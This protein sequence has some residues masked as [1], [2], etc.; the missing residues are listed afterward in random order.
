MSVPQH[1]GPYT[2]LHEVGRGAMGVV[3]LARDTR[4]DRNVALKMLPEGVASNPTRVA[5]FEREG[6][7]L[8]ALNHP[9]IAAIHGLEESGGSKY[10]VLEYVDG[11]TLGQRLRHGAMPLDEALKVCRQIAA[12]AEAAHQHGVIHRDLKPE[13]IKITP[14]GQVKILDFGLAKSVGADRAGAGAAETAT[15]HTNIATIPGATL[16]TPGYMSPEQTRGKPVDKRT[17]VWAFGCIL[18]ECL[19]GRMA[20]HGETVNDAIAAT[21]TGVPDWDHLPP[22]TPDR[23]RDL[24]LRCLEKDPNERQKDLGDARLDI[25]EATGDRSSSHIRHPRRRT[26]NNLPVQVTSFVGRKKELAEVRELLVHSRLVTITG[27]GGCG[28]TRLVLQFAEELVTCGD[29]PDGVWFA[30][31]AAL[32]D[33]TLVPE[34]VATPLGVKEQPGELLRDSLIRHLETKTTLLIIDNCEHLLSACAELVDALLH[35]CPNLRIITSSREGLAIAGEATYRVPSLPVPPVPSMDSPLSGVDVL[36]YEAVKLLAERAAA[37]MPSFS[38]ADDNAHAVARICQRLD[39]IPLAIELAAAR[40]GALSVDEIAKRLD[41]SFRLLTGG[42]RTALPRQRTLRATIDWSYSLLSEEEQILLRRF[43]VFSGGWHLEAAEK[44]CSDEPELE[45]TSASTL[46]QRQILD[47]MTSLVDKSLVVFEETVDGGGRYRL[48]ETVRQYAQEEHSSA[49]EGQAVRDRHVD[50][51]LALAE[52]A[53]PELRGADQAAWLQRLET[54]HENLL[55]ALE[56]CD[57]ADGGAVKALRLSG[58]LW[59]LWYIHGHLHL[60]LRALSDALGRDGATEPTAVRAKTL[61]AA[62][63]L[64]E[65]QSDYTAAKTLLEESLAIRRDLKDQRGIAQSLN[66]LGTVLDEQRDHGAASALYQ[67]A[68]KINRELGNRTAEAN[69]LNN[70]GHIALQLCD[71]VAARRL[72]EESLAIHCELGDQHG[73]AIALNNLG[74]VAHHQGDGSTAQARYQESLATRYDLG[75]KYGIAES[76]QSIAGYA[77]ATGAWE[78]TARLLGA[79]ERLREE[80][81]TALPPSDRA[82]HD[83]D[84]VAARG[85]L[86]ATAFEDIRAGGRAAP[87]EDTVQETLRWL[88]DRCYVLGKDHL[89]TGKS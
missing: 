8:A 74:Q 39:G 42:S 53:E 31:L 26:P 7:A 4:L 25:D 81:G 87:L 73:T 71:H 1:I 32:A 82:E 34:S 27:S 33:P 49:G 60:G 84:V 66:N 89:P 3:Y 58:A 70:L 50:F 76:L 38:V 51:F 24:L 41:D 52:L 59:R 28:K 30:E 72:L 54:E 9:N 44:V 68:V 46:D 63:I 5:R 6:K 75:D 57:V 29:Y 10:L 21:L 14:N 83:H 23:I 77:A 69:N 36:G 37:A 15:M 17:D 35:G 86:G 12:G 13:N 79:A 20:F 18:Y 48:L 11:E 43:S 47:L 62:G 56:W 45:T 65:R 67:E 64:A 78:H 2:I 16:G 85:G 55:A 19:T 61:N 40:A 80:I 88:T 22:E